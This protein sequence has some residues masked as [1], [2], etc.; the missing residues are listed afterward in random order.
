MITEVKATYISCTMNAFF[1]V[2]AGIVFL[3]G[4]W[5]DPANSKP[6]T[7]VILVILGVLAVTA[8]SQL[9]SDTFLRAPGRARQKVFPLE[10][11]VDLAM[12][13]SLGF[14][15]RSIS[16]NMPYAP[17][18]CAL[19]CA[20]LKVAILYAR[21]FDITETSWSLLLT[22]LPETTM[23]LFLACPVYAAS[24]PAWPIRVSLAAALASYGMVCAVTRPKYPWVDDSN[25]QRE[26]AILSD[27]Q[28]IS[29]SFGYFVIALIASIIAIGGS[30]D[31]A[32]KNASFH[33]IL[34][35]SQCACVALT[36]IIHCLMIRRAVAA[37]QRQTSTGS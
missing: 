35:V 18:I 6:G 14:W 34:Y 4:A 29:L 8:V 28:R 2:V 17:V 27:G 30:D 23:F 24:L 13:L 32:A 9:M 22:L 19:L 7:G 31:I 21:R 26:H 5:R 20:N 15:M 11:M 16:Q 33:V 36:E 1:M 25:A 12:L 3:E 37:A 10:R